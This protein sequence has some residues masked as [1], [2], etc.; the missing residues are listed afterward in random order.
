MLGLRATT[1][2][3]YLRGFCCWRKAQADHPVTAAT[4]TGRETWRHLGA[5]M[6]VTRVDVWQA[7]RR[8]PGLIRQ[9]EGLHSENMVGTVGD[10]RFLLNYAAS[11]RERGDFDVGAAWKSWVI[12]SAAVG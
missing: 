12:Q 10:T 7:P 4:E 9:Q 3:A 11:H 8:S 2:A 6:S 1:G 5:R